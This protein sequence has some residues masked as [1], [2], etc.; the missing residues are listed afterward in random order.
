MKPSGHTVLITGGASGIGLALTEQFVRHGNK[1]IVA[2]RSESKLSEVKSRYPEVH[3]IRCD[4]SQEGDINRLVKWLSE[5]H[6][7]L[8][9][10]INNAGIQHNYAFNDWKALDTDGKIKEE[11]EINLIAPIRLI[12]RLLP[13]L[14]RHQEAAIVNISSGLGIAPKKS[15]PVYCATKAGLHIF[16]KALRYQLE[17]TPVKVFEIIPPIVDTAMTSGRGRGKISADQL[18]A[19]FWRSYRRDRL[20]IAIGKVKLLTWLNRLAPGVAEAILKNS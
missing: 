19:E 7:D 10:L 6:P 2:G 4:I 3:I 18:A 1:V 20:E 14:S 11:T 16:T 13:L 12:A 17:S 15:A 9:V 8:S 5:E